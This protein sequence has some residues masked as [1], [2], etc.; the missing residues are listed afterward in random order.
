ML[1]INELD[2]K[3]NIILFLLNNLTPANSFRTTLPTLLSRNNLI[4]NHNAQRG[5]G[6]TGRTEPKRGGATLKI[7]FR[8]ILKVGLRGG[9]RSKRNRVVGGC[10][11]GI[12]V[13]C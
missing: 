13:Y 6:V 5:A 9:G 2:T 10:R 1:K 7:F 3:F 12:D 4:I 11:N 8:K